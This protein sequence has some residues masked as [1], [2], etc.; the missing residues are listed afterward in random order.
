MKIIIAFI[1][2]LLLGIVL[3][4]DNDLGF[5]LEWD[6][7][8]IKEEVCLRW[9]EPIT[10]NTAYLHNIICIPNQGLLKKYD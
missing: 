7:S 1:I 4:Y 10:E 3:F 2:G 8:L 5:H 9:Y 6:R